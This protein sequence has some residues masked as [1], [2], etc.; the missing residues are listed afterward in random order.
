[1]GFI[2]ALADGCGC[3]IWLPVTAVGTAV[4]EFAFGVDPTA[5]SVV[6]IV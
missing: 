5:P 2:K 1:M 3:V 4:W 6:G